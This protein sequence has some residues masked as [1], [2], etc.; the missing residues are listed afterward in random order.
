MSKRFDNK[1]LLYVFGILAVI[2]LLTFIFKIPKEKSTLKV[3]L[4]DMDTNSVTR[5]VI[6]PKFSAGAPF[7]FVKENNMW[8]VKQGNLVSKP[9]R[10][11]IQNIFNEIISLKPQG[12]AAVDKSKWIEF[13]LTD[14]LSTRIKFLNIKG[15]ELADI[16]IGKFTFKRPDNSYGSYGGNNIEGTSFVRVNNEKEIYAVDGFLAL[17]FSGK[18]SD[19]R[20]KSFVRFKK[21]DVL[22]VTFKFPADSSYVLRKKEPGWQVGDIEADTTTVKNY[23]NTLSYLDGQD[24][25]DGYKP[26]SNPEF[27]IIAEGNN[28]LNFTVNCYSEKG[29]NDYILSSSLYP[30]IYFVSKKDGIFDQIFKPQVYFKKK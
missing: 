8:I 30:E 13:E 4:I 27:L 14:S 12:L 21:E 6:I 17:S 10:G 16:Q 3:S 1:K 11:A 28:L 25:K 9:A 7:E 20:D 22:K 2:L 18:F 24:I 5:V 19:W 26:D 23:L 29:S 15:K